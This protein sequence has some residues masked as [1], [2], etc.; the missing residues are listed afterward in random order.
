MA[1]NIDVVMDG[2][3]VGTVV[4]PDA[5]CK[6]FLTASPE[7]RAQRRLTQIQ[8]EGGQAGEGLSLREIIEDIKKRDDQDTNRKDSPLRPAADSILLDTTSLTFL[9]VIEKALQLVEHSLALEG[10]K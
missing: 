10:K 1:K 7:A 8:E 5:Q 4:L 9:Q 6:I 2:R 3:D